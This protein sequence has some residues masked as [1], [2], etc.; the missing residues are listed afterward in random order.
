MSTLF[1]CL[2]AATIKVMRMDVLPDT[3]KASKTIA[4]SNSANV[5]NTHLDNLNDFAPSLKRQTLKKVSYLI[6]YFYLIKSASQAVTVTIIYHL[7]VMH[8]N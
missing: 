1:K 6:L 3:W 2:G 5:I 4:I 7:I 8:H